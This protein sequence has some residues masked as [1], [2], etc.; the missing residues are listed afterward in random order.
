MRAQ[1][2]KE[3]KHVN[4][5]ERGLGCRFTRAARPGPALFNPLY[6]DPRKDATIFHFPDAYETMPQQA[7][8]GH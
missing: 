7:E 3:S 1:E 4:M 5:L 2:L 6:F 8:L